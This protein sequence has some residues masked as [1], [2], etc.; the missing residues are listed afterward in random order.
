VSPPKNISGGDLVIQWVIRLV[1]IENGNKIYERLNFLKGYFSG[2]IVETN[3]ELIKDSFAA[4]KVEA[5][6]KTL[7]DIMDPKIWTV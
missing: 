4:K 7:R 1:Y 2:M 5:H 6:S 3:L